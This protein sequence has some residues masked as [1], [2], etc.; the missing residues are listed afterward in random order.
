MI[1]PFPR[2]DRPL[3]NPGVPP[4]PG[5]LFVSNDEHEPC[6][7]VRAEGMSAFP[8]IAASLGASPQK[9]AGPGMGPAKSQRD[10]PSQMTGRGIGLFIGQV[11][12]RSLDKRRRWGLKVGKMRRGG[13]TFMDLSSGLPLI[14]VVIGWVLGIFTQPLQSA[15]FGPKLLIDCLT[16]P[17][18]IGQ[19]PDNVYMKFRVRNKRKRSVARNCRAYLIAIYQISNNKVIS[20]NLRPD[21]AQLPWEGGDFDPRD[22]PYGASQY[23]DI[24]HFSKEEQSGWIFY[25]KPNYISQDTQL[26]DYRGTYRVEVLVAGDGLNPATMNINID[27]NG[28]WRGAKPYDT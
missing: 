17:G 20:D 4:R 10:G 15:F 22:I 19:G 12:C 25:A 16:A 23:A 18:R 2:E 7:A 3:G 24:V 11:T 21:S 6:R 1:L 28:D 8:P 26:R 27:Y 5:F 14:G 13:A 9:A